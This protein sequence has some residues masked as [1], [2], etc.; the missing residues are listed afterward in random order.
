MQEYK[1]DEIRDITDEILDHMMSPRNYGKIDNASGVGMGVDPQTN[2]FALIYLDID[3]DESI[4]DIK[5]SCNACQDTIIAGSMFT[6]MIKEET[7]R[8]GKETAALM[9]QKIK[10]APPKQQACSGM[11]IKAFDAAALHVEEKK[12]GS[13]EEMKKL[14]LDT[15]CEG[16]ENKEQ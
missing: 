16:V 1:E 12:A 13:I 11:V 14:E 5:F 8:Y 3:S 2:E 7:L 15:S 10:S 4:K 6:E 9:A